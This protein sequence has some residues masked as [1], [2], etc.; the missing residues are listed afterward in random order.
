MTHLQHARSPR[1]V[2]SLSVASLS[3]LLLGGCVGYVGGSTGGGGMASDSPS[4]FSCDNS[5]APTA[6]GL[7]RLSQSQ[8]QN[9]LH[10]LIKFALQ[11]DESGTQTVLSSQAVTAALADYP[12]EQH[13]TV[14]GDRFGTFQRMSQDV[15]DSHI[16]ATYEVAVAV[17]AQL[18]AANLLGTVVGTCATDTKTSN[19]ATCITNFITN[20]GARAL[21]R[22]LT[23]D[24]VTFYQGFYGTSTAI[25]PAAFADTIA[26]FLTAPQ[27]LYLVEHGDQ[28]VSG[29][30]NVFTL[31]AYEVASRL[32]YQFWDTMP[33][34]ALLS[35]AAD[36]SLVSNPTVY[37]A[38]VDRLL[39]DPRAQ[40]TFDGFFTDYFKLFQSD[41][42]NLQTLGARDSDPTFMTFAGNDLPSNMLGA[43]MVDEVLN[44][45]R[46]F[47]FT[48]PGSYADLLTNDYSFATTPDLAAIY[49]IPAWDGSS[50]PP[51]FPAG[52][53]PGF[54]TRAAF[55]ATGNVTTRPIM[56]GVFIRKFVL[57]DT[58]PDPPMNASNTPVDTSM[59]NTRQAVEA[60]TEQDGTVCASCH[61]PIIN[62]LGFATENF[63]ALGRLRTTQPL[64]DASGNIT[65]QI[66]IDTNSIPQIVIGDLTPSTG[67]SDMVGLILASQQAQACFARNYFRFTFHRLD[68]PATDGCALEGIRQKVMSGTLQDAIRNVALAQAF[69][70]R[71]FQ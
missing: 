65:Q 19:D 12:P 15:Q 40:A 26:G 70:T 10:D 43:S 57:C 60:I 29:Q 33:D 58:I 38:Q 39:A 27:F 61:K 5:A 16:R 47:T 62:P 23:S 20:F 64:F 46:Y 45:A 50:Q 22:P 53:R 55:L 37:A 63:D 41:I 1:S 66:P 21:R 2:A 49:G 67:A 42:H 8:Y 35:A 52:V 32:S 14:P 59:Q 7:P 56:K 31:S 51:S 36:G 6:L 28:P 17:G 68:D 11:G 13:P 24:E 69:T 18:T 44:M 54:L 3:V 34:D 25:T 71:N 4:A 48:Q 9:T 30:Q